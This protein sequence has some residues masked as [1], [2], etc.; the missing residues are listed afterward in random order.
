[1]DNAI[2]ARGLVKTYRGDVRALDGVSLAVEAGSVFGLLGPNGA[3]KSTA[4]KIL[5]TLS[6]PDAGEAFVAGHD[7]LRHPARVRLRHRLSSR[8]SRASTCRRPGARTCACRAAC[9]G[10]A[11]RRC[12]RVR[13][14]SSSASGSPTPP[15]APCKTYSGGMQRKLDVAVGAHAPAAGPL[16]RRADDRPG[17]RGARGHVEGDRAPRRRRGADHPDDDALPRGGRQPRAAAGDRRP[18]Q[19]GRRGHAGRAQGRA[20]RRR[21]RRRARGAAAGRRGPPGARQGPRICTTSPWRPARCARGP[22]AARAP[23]RPCSRR[24]R[25][26]ASRS[27]R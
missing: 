7:V 9:T 24:S 19:G 17:P 22:T 14:S 21:D 15:T 8:R 10:C 16:P 12:A 2:E 25:R 18:R 13:R 6:R 11:A 23:S 4:V 3:G 20:A 1:M 5:T 27:P 26:R